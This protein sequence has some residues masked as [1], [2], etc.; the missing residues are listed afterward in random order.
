M[1][2]LR[3]IIQVI[4][5][6]LL[7]NLVIVTVQGETLEERLNNEVGPEK[8]YDT[9]LSPMYLKTNTTEENVNPRNGDLSI[10]QTDYTL[11]GRNGMDLNL[12][13]IYKSSG[14]NMGDMQVKYVNGAWVD[15]VETSVG[16]ASFFENRYNLGLGM[17]FSFET[18]E[19]NENEDSSSSIIYH[20]ETGDVYILRAYLL[21]DYDREEWFKNDIENTLTNTESIFLPKGQTVRDHYIAYS[22]H[23]SNDQEQSKYVLVKKDGMKTYFTEDGRIL[24]KEDQHGN[25]ITFRYTTLEYTV[26]QET[27]KKELISEITDTIGRVVSIDYQEDYTYQVKPIGTNVKKDNSYEEMQNPDTKHS[28]DLEGHFKVVISLPDDK[29]I[30]YEKSAA[31]VNEEG[32]VLRTRLQTVY[33]VDDEAKYHYWYEQPSL[34]FSFHNEEDYSVYNR[35]EYL[36]QIDFCKTNEIR[37]YTYDNYTK[38][39]YQGSMEYRKLF[40]REKLA[41]LDYQISEND[42]LRRW[43]TEVI[44]RKNYDYDNEPDGYGYTGYLE[45]DY[46]YLNNTYRY[47]TTV[48]DLLNNK[49]ITTYDGNHKNVQTEEVGKDHKR[50]LT[51]NYDELQLINKKIIEEYPVN[52][53]QVMGEPVTLIENFRYDK[54]GNLTNYTGVEANRDADG[55]PMY[56]EHTITY[57]YDYERYHSLVQRTWKVNPNTMAQENYTLDEKGNVIMSHQGMPEEDI[58]VKYAYDAYGNMIKEEAVAEDGSYTTYYE[59]G[60]DALG[61]HYQGAYLTKSYNIIDGEESRTTY[62]Y[63]SEGLLIQQTTPNGHTYQYEY[64]RLGRVLKNIMPDGTTQSYTYTEQPFENMQ[65]AMKDQKGQEYRYT[66]NVQGLELERGYLKDGQWIVQETNQYNTHGQ[67][68]ETIDGNGNK[69]EFTYNSDGQLTKKQWFDGTVLKDTITYTYSIQEGE[70]P[71]ETIFT[72]EEGYQHYFYFDIKNQ[73]VLSKTT[74]DHITYYE[75]R[76]QYDYIGNTIE[77]I[78]ERGHKSTYVYDAAGRLITEIDPMGYETHYTYNGAHMLTQK[79]EPGKRFTTRH[80]DEAKR[81][82]KESIH[83]D[84]EAEHYYSAYAYDLEGQPITIIKGKEENGI[85][86]ISQK[87]N[88]VYN[89]MGQVVDEYRFI[90]ETDYNHFNYTYD[91][92]GN[93]TMVK[94][95]TNKSKDSYFLTENSYGALDLLIKTQSSYVEHGEN[96]QVSIIN[97]TYDNNKNLISQSQLKEQGFVTETYAYDYRDRLV[98]QITPQNDTLDKT[99]TFTYNGLNHILTE[100]LSDGINHYRVIHQYDG[101]GRKIQTIDPSGYMTRYQYDEKGNLIKTVDSRYANEPIETAAGKVYVYDQNDRLIEAGIYEAGETKVLALYNYDGRGN[102]IKRVNSLGYNEQNP[103]QS[104]G[105]TFTYNA[106]DEIKTYQTAQNNKQNVQTPYIYHYD[107]NGRVLSE[108]NP[109]GYTIKTEYDLLG[110]V[111]QITH[112]NQGITTYQYDLSGRRSIKETD[113]LGYTTQWINNQWDE[114]E[115]Q[116]QPDNGKVSV[117]YTPEGNIK[118]QTHSSGSQEIYEYDLVGNIILQKRLIDETDTEYIYKQ[119][120]HTYDVRDLLIESVVVELRENKTSQEETLWDIKEKIEYTYDKNQNLIEVKGPG[121]QKTQYEYDPMGQVITTKEYIKGDQWSITRN[122]YDV[123]GNVTEKSLLVDGN[124]LDSASLSQA[125][126]DHEYGAKVLVT[127]KFQYNL[128]GLVTKRIDPLGNETRNAYNLSGD[129]ISTTNPLGASTTY[130]YDAMGQLTQRSTPL[131]AKTTFEYDAT[132]NIIKKNEP[133]KDGETATY[134]YEYDVKDQLVKEILPEGV[135]TNQGMV[136]VYDFRGEITEIYDTDNRLVETRTYD[137][138]GRLIKKVEGLRNSDEGTV[139]TYNFDDKVTSI[140]NPL[141]ETSEMTYDIF[142]NVLTSTNANGHTTVY[143]YNEDQTL[144][145][146]DNPDGGKI[147]YSYDGLGRLIETIN[148]LGYVLQYGY[149]DF[150]E[151]QWQ[152]DPLGYEKHFTYDLKGQLTARTDEIGSQTTYTYDPVGQVTQIE[153]PIEERNG[154]TIYKV[155][156]NRYNQEGNLINQTVYEKTTRDNLKSISYTYY[157]DGNVKTQT[158]STGEIIQY[159][160]DKNGNLI[161][162]KMTYTDGTYKMQTLAYDLHNRLIEEINYLDEEGI[163]EADVLPDILKADNGRIKSITR[164]TYDV[165][166]NRIQRESP[167]AFLYDAQQSSRNPYVTNYSYDALNRLVKTSHTYEGKTY[168]EAIDYDAVGNTIAITDLNGHTR[169]ITY[170]PM[171]RPIQETDPEGHTMHYAY[172]LEGNKI[173]ETNGK[174]QSIVYGYDKLNRIMTLTDAYGIT[175]EQRTYDPKGNLITTTDALGYKTEYTYD[176]AN[177]LITTTDPETKAQGLAYTQKRTYDIYGNLLS[178]M[179]A[180]GGVLV[181]TYDPRG[182][183]TSMTDPLGATTTYTYD[184]MGNQISRIDGNGRETQYV[185]NNHGDLLRVTNPLEETISYT[186]DIVGNLVEEVDKKGQTIIYQYN[187]RNKMVH[188][189][190]VDTKDAI[191]YTY[192]IL[193]NR[194]TM[195]D[196]TGQTTYRYNKNNQLLQRSKNDTIEITYTYDLL[197]NRETVN[198]EGYTIA[199][200]YDQSNRMETVNYNGNVTT[201]SYDARGNRES[202]TYDNGIE[203]AYAYDGNNQVIGIEN[204]KGN[205]TYSELEYTYD[206]TGKV[207]SKNNHL[208]VTQYTYDL[209]GRLTKEVAPGYTTV[210]TYDKKGNRLSGETRYKAL[211]NTSFIYTDT[212]EIAQYQTKKTHYIYNPADQ[213]ISSTEKMIDEQGIEILSKAT[214]YTYDKNGNQTS[215]YSD[216]THP[217][218]LMMRQKVEGETITDQT[219]EAL[220]ALIDRTRYTYNGFNQVT[221]V[222]KIAEGTRNITHYTY[223]GEGLRTSKTETTREGNNTTTFLY[224]RQYVILETTENGQETFYLRGINYIG[225]ERE[226]LTYYLYNGHGDVIHT[227]DEAGTIKNQYAYDAFGNAT[228]TLE[229]EANA[230]RY[231][232]EYYDANT[233]LYYLRARYYNPYIGRF[234]SEDSYWGE[235][236]NPLSLNLYTYCHNDPVNYVDPSGHFAVGLLAAGGLAAGAMKLASGI[237]KAIS[238]RTGTKTS[239]S[240]GGSSGTRRS[241]SSS[242]NS[243]NKNT[244]SSSNTSSTSNKTSNLSEVYESYIES[245]SNRTSSNNGSVLLSI[246]SAVNNMYQSVNNTLSSVVNRVSTNSPIGN[247]NISEEKEIRP[248]LLVASSNIVENIGELYL[249]INNRVIQDYKVVDGT[250]LAPLTDVIGG[251]GGTVKPTDNGYVV[252]VNGQV[253][254]YDLNQITDGIGLASDYSAFHIYDQTIYV[255]VSETGNKLGAN[256]RYEKRDGKI[257]GLIVTPK[258]RVRWVDNE[259]IVVEGTDYFVLSDEGIKMLMHIELPYNSYNERMFKKDTNGNVIGIFPYDVFDNGITFGYGHHA[260]YREVMIAK[261]PFEINLVKKYDVYDKLHND[262]NPNNNRA[263]PLMNEEGSNWMSL[264]EAEDLLERDVQIFGK[265]INTF[266]SENNISI[267]QH[268]FDALVIYTFL[269]GSMSDN[270]ENLLIDG[271]RNTGQWSKAFGISGDPSFGG[272]WANRTEKTLDLFINDNYIYNEEEIFR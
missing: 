223:N 109:L 208:G 140:T 4:L 217:H 230:I 218:R 196:E 75:K 155:E 152:R 100:T 70:Y 80:Y 175:V 3:K 212:Q 177:R 220:S 247:Q 112:P 151:V 22:D 209:A 57:S 137:D 211:Q 194:L 68:T 5:P 54:Y 229:V 266:I 2:K 176:L 6:I 258:D 237:N 27:V 125:Q 15:Y 127:H 244:L 128:A 260:S 158:A 50:I 251:L 162:Q 199:Y 28:G 191:G 214:T 73:L 59:Y 65:I 16:N 153:T 91:D 30:V 190:N 34:G 32:Q 18:L 160:Y 204:K 156:E 246:G 124:S 173:K 264:E 182:L 12:T 111:V 40:R 143:T 272:G 49:V 226:A 39:L 77:A 90:N 169:T 242:S 45:G 94:N 95:Y 213:L 243:S 116:I 1:K 107:G 135:S 19:V 133:Y 221:S 82:E 48:T 165:R 187:S 252:N 119:T 161:H 195:S 164:Y 216:Y 85:Q 35:Y 179:D 74:P 254:H 81:L 8:H 170:D 201:Y 132:G 64:D 121:Q 9:H 141:K 67:V 38:R 185:Y 69:I 52:N 29:T 101:L 188:K 207:T 126:F 138:K 271:N 56:T 180:L 87:N 259:A 108:S 33:D 122:T 265:N 222:E 147:T 58:V 120:T 110:Q 66:F 10:V 268:E 186:Y 192:D 198:I 72:D 235:D 263:R 248:F 89:Q 105:E 36:T 178:L 236:D 261:D 142:G 270:V 183:L 227:V 205:Y 13:R 171:N 106:I 203:I 262:G 31:L 62:A 210:Y 144:A 11:Q 197:G 41:K 136:Y 43:S 60:V 46:N 145:Q 21:D 193:G 154:Q 113:S 53:G 231:S 96:G 240:S 149:N 88:Y 241:N 225:M 232:G 206:L 92:N 20:T 14:A 157:D 7:F 51:T 23:Y 63:N 166:G 219:E 26:G 174:N 181:Y 25:Q 167:K 37:R 79:E 148:A 159:D 139:Y 76:Y 249:K 224:D 245:G 134:S 184:A 83:L 44:E 117:T 228:F 250:I 24:A 215:Q 202:L 269:R 255:G 253:I 130:A 172:D 86:T 256:I 234:I 189:E 267:K 55:E 150:G 42:F 102:L 118:S 168:Q 114:T 97:Y 47:E 71:Y 257:S 84:G 233:G 61:N 146:I 99:K 239:S 98:Q 131:G 129:I 103:N 104:I 163:K 93:Q 238:S 123:L 115:Q 200:T 78:D 17:R